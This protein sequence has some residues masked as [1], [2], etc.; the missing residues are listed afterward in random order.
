MSADLIPAVRRPQQ[1]S[2]FGKTQPLGVRGPKKLVKATE[3]PPDLI[4]IRL[5]DAEQRL[6][7]I[8]DFSR[9]CRS[10]GARKQLVLIVCVT[11]ETPPMS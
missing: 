6:V 2:V 7:S 11:T 4:A 3:L 1:L 10:E 5:L 9:G 8:P